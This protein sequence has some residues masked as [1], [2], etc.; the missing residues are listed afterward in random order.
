MPI[1]NFI[2]PHLKTTEGYQAAHS[3]DTLHGKTEVAVEDIIKLDANEN[4]YGCSPRVQAALGNFVKYNI[5]PDAE[6]TELRKALSVYTGTPADTIV[7][8]N[9][10]GEL[11]DYVLHLFVGPG[12][13]VVNFVPTFDLYRTRTERLNG[14]LVEVE[15]NADFAIDIAKAKAAVTP[16]T[17]LII[18]TNPNNPDGTLTPEKDIRAILDTG[19][20]MLVDE[21]YYEFSN[22]TVVPL[23][24]KYDNLMILR[25]FSKW[26]G[27]AGLRVGYGVFPPVIAAYLL[28]NKLPYNVSCAA[29]VA[30][31]ES[32]K[33]TDYL[34]GTVRKIIAERERLLRE[35]KKIPYLKPYPS[36]ANYVLCLVGNG[37]AGEL[38]EKMQDKG[39]LVRFWDRPLMRD[40]IRIS[41]GKPEHTD[42]VIKVLKAMGSK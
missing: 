10:S 19:V 30:V 34:M 4:V 16:K 27:L 21:A 15:R 3:T 32:L 8:G 17:K 13:E 6:Q 18:L 38:R 5:Y 7:L 29:Q 22:V 42:A 31:L 37:R 9:G 20:P 2:Q 23:M 1:E 11:L 36:K 28:K 33:D 25:T 14:R 26:T 12:D 24:K 40:F 39:I 35:L 41:V